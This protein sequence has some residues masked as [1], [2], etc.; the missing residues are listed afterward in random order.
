LP[1]GVLSLKE[2]VVGLF[3]LPAPGQLA[4]DDDPSRREEALFEHL[5][6]HIPLRQDGGLMDLVRMSVSVRPFAS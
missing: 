4:A 3:R 5:R 2:D 6:H 1:E